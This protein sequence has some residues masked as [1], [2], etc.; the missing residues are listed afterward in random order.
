MGIR[1]GKSVFDDDDTFW[2]E[3][4]RILLRGLREFYFQEKWSYKASLLHLLH[5]L[6]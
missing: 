5:F 4:D 3:Q 2:K 1:C 6:I